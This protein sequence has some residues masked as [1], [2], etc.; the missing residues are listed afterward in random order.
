MKQDISYVCLTALALSFLEHI[1]NPI[2]AFEL[3]ENSYPDIQVLPQGS[4]LD[5]QDKGNK[6]FQAL[7]LDPAVYYGQLQ[8]RNRNKRPKSGKKKRRKNGDLLSGS[9]SGGGTGEKGNTLKYS[10][11]Q[12][13]TPPDGGPVE[14]CKPPSSVSAFT[15]MNFALSAITIAANLVRGHPQF[16][17]VSN[18]PSHIAFMS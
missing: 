13:Q 17:L 5:P 15:F 8:N 3:S 10:F 18:P 2:Q 14:T 6:S 11:L 1:P 9:F 4:H 7:P 16:L 12:P